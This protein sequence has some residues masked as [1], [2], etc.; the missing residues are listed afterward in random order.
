MDEISLCKSCG[1]MTKTIQQGFSE[2]Y[3]CGKCKEFK[4]RPTEKEAKTNG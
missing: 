1:C 2:Y 3:R 4:L